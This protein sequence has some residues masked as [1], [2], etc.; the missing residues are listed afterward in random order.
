MYVI[1]KHQVKDADAFFSISRMAAEGAPPDV[2]GRQF[3]P[4]R[5]GTEAVCLWEADSLEAV[6]EYLDPLIGEAGDN[7]YFEVDTV[8]AIGIPDPIASGARV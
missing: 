6:R 2:H 5:D 4:S 1:A 3:C 7:T 8:R